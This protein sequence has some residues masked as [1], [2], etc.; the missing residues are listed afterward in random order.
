M[1]A[2]GACI[3]NAD[4]G[5][6]LDE[7]QVFINHKTTADENW[8]QLCLDEFWNKNMDVKNKILSNIKDHGVDANTAMKTFYNWI[9]KSDDTKRPQD[10]IDNM[11]LMSD[12]AGIDIGF[13]NYYL[14]EAG[15]PSMNYIIGNVYKPSRDS[16][17]F[18]MGVGLATPSVSLWGAEDAACKKLNFTMPTNP[19]KYTHMPVE[20]AKSIFYEIYQIE[21][22]IKNQRN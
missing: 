1:M 17:S 11:I 18:H 4:N 20:D 3:G 19:Y 5:E 21:N 8:E 10:L 14:S 22:A 16:S 9:N 6:I 13:L 15:L 12:T 2:I 7:F